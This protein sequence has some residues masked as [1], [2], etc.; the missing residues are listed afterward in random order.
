VCIAL[1]ASAER[2]FA[3]D[4]IRKDSAPLSELSRLAASRFPNLTHAELALLEFAD[5]GNLNHG[6]FAA[7]GPSPNPLDASND[8][9]D[10]ATWTRDRN[11]HGGRTRT[12]KANGR[13]SGSG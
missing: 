2:G 6:E 8:P 3:S 5:I 9:K 13:S 12:R 4:R 11:I 7:A 1:L 10:A